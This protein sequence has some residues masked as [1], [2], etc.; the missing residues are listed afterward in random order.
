MEEEDISSDEDDVPDLDEAGELEPAPAA[1]GASG[2]GCIQQAAG[3]GQR[4]SR[5]GQQAPR[6]DSYCGSSWSSMGGTRL[7]SHVACLK[8]P[9]RRV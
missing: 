5:F 8:H 6:V 1:A 3:H 7:S 4:S 9:G 2:A